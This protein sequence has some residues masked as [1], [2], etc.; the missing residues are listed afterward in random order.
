MFSYSGCGLLHTHTTHA[1][2]AVAFAGSA[3]T[4]ASAA[5]CLSLHSSPATT[6]S[7]CHYR[8]LL[9][10]WVSCTST[11][12]GGLHKCAFRSSF[13]RYIPL[14]SRISA[15]CVLYMVLFGF[16]CFSAV[17]CF[18]YTNI[19]R[20]R[21]L[22]LCLSLRSSSFRLIT[23]WIFLT[24]KPAATTFC[25]S[26]CAIRAAA[27][28]ITRQLRLNTNA[29]HHCRLVHL[30]L[31]SM[32]NQRLR[33]RRFNGSL[34][35]ALAVYCTYCGL[36]GSGYGVSPPSRSF[37]LRVPFMPLSAGFAGSA[38]ASPFCACNM[39]SRAWPFL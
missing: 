22:P 3:T 16:F 32:V 12:R 10:A 25:A 14:P 5:F 2:D 4:H 39:G 24:T 1:A 37:Y 19:S 15:I 18:V 23:S 17:Y 9:H 35:A 27:G 20:L 11:C 8:G 34:G 21:L 7:A 26:W 13:C 36:C 38:A 30:L 28:E 31:R 29:V 33:R 6:V